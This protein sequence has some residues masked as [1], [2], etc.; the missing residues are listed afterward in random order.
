VSEAEEVRQQIE[1]LWP[2]IDRSTITDEKVKQVLEWVRKFQR[3]DKRKN[4]AVLVQECLSED[5]DIDEKYEELVKL[6]KP[7]KGVQ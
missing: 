4:A 3:R 6:V 1:A 7:V 5:S 2:N